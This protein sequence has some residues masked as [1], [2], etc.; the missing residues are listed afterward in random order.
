M[1]EDAYTEA[2]RAYVAAIEQDDTAERDRLARVLD[3]AT[4]LEHGRDEATPLGES[5]RA[6]AA[7]GVSVFPLQPRG[8]I[9]LTANGFK[10]ATTDLEQIAAWWQQWPDANIGTPTGIT[11]D[12]VDIDGTAGLRTM[13]SGAVPLV[14]TL[15]VLGVALTARD[16]GRHLYV[17]ASGRGNKAALYPA[18]DYRGV[19]GY[20]V[21]PPSIG[22]SGRRYRWTRPL[23]LSSEAAA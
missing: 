21:A 7:A 19:G 3:V 20:V 5:A 16:G 12:V 18:V 8:K 22:G 9:P 13:Y 11:F 17:P 6:I 14:D 2:G 1:T 4:E 23:E 15:T 10:N